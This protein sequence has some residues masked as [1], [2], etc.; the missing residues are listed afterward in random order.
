M[1]RVQISCQNLVS[2]DGDDSIDSVVAMH[3]E[4][5][6]TLLGQT[7]KQKQVEWNSLVHLD[8]LLV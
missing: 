3:E 1:L 5:N 8:W 6:G 4:S 2:P 7:D